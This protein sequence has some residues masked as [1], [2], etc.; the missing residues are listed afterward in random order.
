MDSERVY[1]HLYKINWICVNKER[2]EEK[3]DDVDIDISN[4]SKWAIIRG[5]VER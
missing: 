3:E 2:E 4:K 5:Y 1:T